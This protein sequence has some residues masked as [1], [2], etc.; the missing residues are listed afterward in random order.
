MQCGQYDGLVELATI[1]ALCNDS[2]LD[3]NEVRGAPGPG[4]CGEP[5]ILF[6]ALWATLGQSQLRFVPWDPLPWLQLIPRRCSGSPGMV[7]W[8]TASLVGATGRGCSL[9]LKLFFFFPAL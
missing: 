7:Q 6:L 5:A 9:K 8:A 1:C 4:W 2:S 3:Y